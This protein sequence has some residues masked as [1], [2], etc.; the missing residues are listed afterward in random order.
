MGDS[1]G[2]NRIGMK[3]RGHQE[4]PQCTLPLIPQDPGAL[5][6]VDG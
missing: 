3:F 1:K 5:L 4:L 2:E 6:D